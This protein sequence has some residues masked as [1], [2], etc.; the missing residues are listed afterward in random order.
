[1][2]NVIGGIGT[3]HVPAIGG[4][5]AKGLQNHPYWSPFFS[6]FDKVHTWLDKSETGRRR[7]FLKRP[8]AKLLSR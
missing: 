4:A 7:G 8:W 2:A 1:M 3:T 6:A 5:I